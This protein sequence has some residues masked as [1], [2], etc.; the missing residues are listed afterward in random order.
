MATAAEKIEALETALA[1]GVRQVIDADG[2][3][4]TYASLKDIQNA[5]AALKSNQANTAGR[6]GF[7][8]SKFKQAAG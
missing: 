8:I 3:S 6:R 2:R 7:R 5:L 1:R 4:V